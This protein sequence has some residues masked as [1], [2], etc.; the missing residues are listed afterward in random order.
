MPRYSV[1]T[2][3]GFEGIEWFVSD[4]LSQ[5]DYQMAGLL[6]TSFCYVFSSGNPHCIGLSIYPVNL[7]KGVVAVSGTYNF[8]YYIGV[9]VLEGHAYNPWLK[10]NGSSE[11]RE[12]DLGRG[13]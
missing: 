9:P 8:D 7:Y 2:N 10:K 12:M 4:D 1:F 6:G 5:W 3:P 11:R 13:D